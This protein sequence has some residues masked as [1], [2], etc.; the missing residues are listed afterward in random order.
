MVHKK[1]KQLIFRK[2]INCH[3]NQIYDCFSLQTKGSGWIYTIYRDID[4]NIE[5][6]YAP[7][8]NEL[9][10][11]ISQKK[12]NFHTIAKG[13]I[14]KEINV[15]KTLCELGYRSKHR[16]IFEYSTAIIRHLDFLGWP[17]E[18]PKSSRLKYFSKN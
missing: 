4:N 13:S 15:I 8:Y 10:D 16:G 1:S 7:N 12:Y 14:K 5:I 9:K 3:S 11:L 2:Y 18:K 6:G 17:I